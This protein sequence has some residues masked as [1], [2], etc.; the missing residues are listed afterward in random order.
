MNAK[1]KQSFE[2]AFIKVIHLKTSIL[3]DNVYDAHTEYMNRKDGVKFS[4]WKDISKMLKIPSKQ[5][6]D[7]Y[8][9]TWS[10]QFFDDIAPYRQQIKSWLH[11]STDSIQ[12]VVSKVSSRLTHLYPLLNLH[13]QTLYQFVNYQLKNNSQ[14]QENE[15]SSLFSLE[16]ETNYYQLFTV[17]LDFDLK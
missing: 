16:M 5:I 4:I 8:H 3:F 9:N 14:P 15:R 7:F 10:K 11:S 17:G 1:L 2:E 6:H 13:Y 12:V